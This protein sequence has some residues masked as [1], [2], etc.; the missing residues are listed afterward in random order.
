ME[1]VSGMRILGEVEEVSLEEVSFRAW[2]YFLYNFDGNF[3]R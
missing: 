1:A 2:G 3:W